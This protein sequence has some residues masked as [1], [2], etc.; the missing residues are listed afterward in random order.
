[1]RKYGNV[2]TGSLF[3]VALIFASGSVSAGNAYIRA[4]AEEGGQ[5]A[6]LELND[7]DQFSLGLVGCKKNRRKLDLQLVLSVYGKGAV[8]SELEK[9]RSTEVDTTQGLD[10]CINGIC[11]ENEFRAESRPW[12]NVL[13]ND[14]S[15]EQKREKIRSL[16]VIIPNESMKYEYQ[17]D[18]D[19]ILKK[20]CRET[21]D[22]NRSTRS[23]VPRPL[24]ILRHFLR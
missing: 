18:I 14:I 7:S 17:G 16:R 6:W 19:S 8:P 3:L 9:L 11:E 5:D 15:I 10:F 4:G 22:Q 23:S 20:I 2:L 13:Y 12:G 1:M 24:Q 21:S